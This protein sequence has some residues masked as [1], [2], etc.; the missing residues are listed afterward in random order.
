MSKAAS[1]SEAE[2]IVSI[3]HPCVALRKQPSCEATRGRSHCRISR[4]HTSGKESS[5]ELGICG[6]FSSKNLSAA[7][8]GNSLSRGLSWNDNKLQQCFLDSFTAS[9]SRET[10]Q[11]TQD[12]TLV[13]ATAVAGA[14]KEEAFLVLILS[15]T[16]AAAGQAPFRGFSARKTSKK[17]LNPK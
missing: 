6:C 14:E 12:V 3:Q 17:I 10:L 4:V 1:A 2:K 8:S 11:S 5:W 7:W 15:A 16:S 13:Q 9:S